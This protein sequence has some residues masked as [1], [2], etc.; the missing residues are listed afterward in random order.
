MSK[1]TKSLIAILVILLVTCIAMLYYSSAVF[2]QLFI[3]LGMAYVL[4]P[5]V[6]LL[7]K[8][9]LNRIASIIIVFSLT[10]IASIGFTTFLIISI[11]SEFSSMQ[12]NL[13]AYAQ[14]LYDITPK[15]I[16]R[17]LDIETPAKLYRHMDDLT[18]Q[19][20]NI[21]PDLV[22]PVLKFIQQAFSSTLN[23]IL[24]LLGYLI[25]PLY[26]FYLLADM[27]QLKT[28]IDSLIPN[29]YRD[30]YF[31]KLNEV[32]T[33]LS[34]FIRGQL[35]VCAILAVLYSIGLVFIGIDLAVAI[36]TLAGAAF[37]IPYVGTIIGIALS[38]LM[39]LLK[40]HDLLHP[41]LCLGWFCIVQG[42]E[43]MIITPKVVGDTVGLHPLTTIVALLVGGQ[44]FGI[45]GMLLAV[46]VA[47]VLQIFLRSLA[48]Y[49]RNSEFY[50]GC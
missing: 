40:Y 38:M 28:F 47:A 36:G 2:L 9:G 32:N 19:L 22:K 44:I 10:I 3:A 5:M 41:L 46:P 26:L 29:R 14:H 48:D 24:A 4:N 6:T 30:T 35:M 13:P 23:V 45:M 34:G 39:A 49:Y 1:N 43:G 18:Q 8:R 27:P 15:E 37:I 7:E 50:K 31:S 33:V 21:A 42:I 25:I 17:Y 11:S 20:Q 16:K 12:L